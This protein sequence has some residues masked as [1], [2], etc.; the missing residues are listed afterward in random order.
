MNKLLLLLSFTFCCLQIASAQCPPP[1][2]PDSGNTC[3]EAPILCENLDGYCNTINN[4]NF[5]QQFQGCSNQY[6]LN[7]D[8]WFAFTAGTTSITIQVTPSNCSNNG[9]SAGLQAGIYHGCG[10]QIMDLQCACSED[11]F[12]LT[13]N[14]YVVGEVY[15]FVLDGC[16]GDVC[17]YAID[18]LAGSTVGVSPGPPSPIVGDSVFCANTSTTFSIDPV[19]GATTYNWTI[20]PGNVNVSS[21]TTNNELTI[22]WGNSYLYNAPIELCVS[23][24]NACYTNPNVSCK[25]IKV[26]QTATAGIIGDATICIGNNSTVDIPVTLSGVPPW[27]F[28]PTLNGVPQTPVVTDTFPYILNVNQPGAWNII[29]FTSSELMCPGDAFGP[30]NVTL[31]TVRVITISFCPGESVMAGGQVYTQPGIIRDTLPG[32]FSCNALIDFHLVHLPQPTRTETISLCPGQPVVINGQTYTQPGTVSYTIP[33]PGC[34]TLV[35]YHLQAVTPA[36]SNVTIQCP[37]NISI[38]PDPGTVPVEISYDPPTASTDCVCPGVN[39][40][41][42]SGLPSGAGFPNGLTKVCYTATDSCGQSAD[43]CFNVTVRELQP[44]DVKVNGCIRYELLSI[45]ADQDKN[46][47]YRIKVTNNCSNKLIYT[48]IE[49]PDAVVAL[50]P[51]HLSVFTSEDGRDYDVRNPNYSPFYSIR[52]KSTTDSIANGESDIFQYTLPAQ[53]D[54]DYI[55]VTTRL[56]PQL[57]VEAHLNTFNCPV[58]MARPREDGLAAL[59]AEASLYPN[60]NDG[61]FWVDVAAWNSAGVQWRIFNS[62]GALLQHGRSDDPLLQLQLDASAPQGLYFVELIGV[63]GQRS[64]LRFILE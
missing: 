27:Q 54:P 59:Q 21:S 58:G 25:T 38:I 45:N 46:Q 49:L 15:Y 43:C 55:H 30:Y 51:P 57:F 17:D 18:V 10:G 42:T 29:N 4:N 44:C 12:I 61:T 11:P 19:F 33:G 53:S 7:N 3:P 1:G 48:A 36:P 39:L 24:S 40:E 2:F 37:Q 56:A 23:V 16:F 28:T 20:S 34:D 31:D 60:P 14:N 47:T 26:V 41:L 52:Y 13:S 22:N 63:E 9:N 32:S 8:E 62:Q 50:T 6:V 35:T 64:T 5:P